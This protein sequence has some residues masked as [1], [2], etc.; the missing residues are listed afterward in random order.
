MSRKTINT[1]WRIKI[2]AR[3]KKNDIFRTWLM[4]NDAFMR[5]TGLDI[6]DNDHIYDID[7]DTALTI[8]DK[9]LKYRDYE[10][11]VLNANEIDFNLLENPK[12]CETIANMWLHDHINNEILS[13]DQCII[14]GSS[15]G[16]FV[17]SYLKN[18]EIMNIKSDAFVNESVR[19]FNLICKITKRT[20]L[21]DFEALDIVIERDK[22]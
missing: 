10:F 13:L 16:T 19:V 11:P 6:D 3:K 8:K 18:G 17:L 14:P 9:F 2:M 15:K 7:K 21:Y 4:F 5:E 22:K 12:L 20:H 1:L